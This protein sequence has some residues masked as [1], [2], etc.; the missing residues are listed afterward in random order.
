MELAKGKKFER[1]DAGMFL[2]TVIDLVEMEKVPTRFGEKNRVRIHW[3]LSRLDGTPVLDSQGAPMTVVGTYNATTGKGAELVKRVSQ[4]L[5]GPFP[6]ITGKDGTEQLAQ[7]LIGRSNVL[8]LVKSENPQD[9]EDPY[10]NID[11]IAPLPEGAR[12]PAIPA[13][14]VRFKNRPKTQAGP[15]GVPVQTYAQPPAA[16]PAPA[17]ASTTIQP[18]PEQIAAYLA[19]QAAQNAPTSNPTTTFAQPAPAKTANQPF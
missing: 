7:I 11:G 13:N 3:V 2:G 18:T 4:I 12:P 15:Y 8:L 17:A 10:T 16:A 5:N 19:S 1:A 9:P 14:Y 6:L